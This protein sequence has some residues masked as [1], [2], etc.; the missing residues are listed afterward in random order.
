MTF[1][2]IIARKI[3]PLSLGLVVSFSITMKAQNCW[4]DAPSNIVYR[5]AAGNA[6]SSTLTCTDYKFIKINIHFM[7]KSNGSGN[8]R[9]YDD[10][11]TP[12]NPSANGYWYAQSLVDEANLKLANNPQMRLPLG[13]TTPNPTISIRLVLSGVYFHRDDNFYN[14]TPNEFT[15]TLNNTYGININ[16]EMNVYAQYHS[17]YA[18]SGAFGGIASCIGPCAT[19][20]V[21][22]AGIWN[23]PSSG[24]PPPVMAPLMNHEF[25]HN[26]GLNHSWSGDACSDTP[27]NLNEWCNLTS[28]SNNMMD[29]NCTQDAITPC[30]LTIMHSVVDNSY[31]NYTVC[32]PSQPMTAPFSM[33]SQVCNNEKVYLDGS[34]RTTK[35]ESGY[36]IEINKTNAYGSQTNLGNSYSQSFSG[37]YGLIDLSQLYTFVPGNFYKVKLTVTGSACNSGDTEETWIKI[38]NST[39]FIQ[40]QTISTT[41]SLFNICDYAI[42]TN[43]DG[44]QTS[45]NVVVTNTANLKVLSGQSI[46]VKTTTHFQSGSTVQLKA[47]LNF[48]TGTSY[49][50]KSGAASNNSVTVQQADEQNEVFNI[51]PSPTAGIFE[52]AWLDKN[53]NPTSMVIFNPMGQ[54]IL[55]R[56]DFINVQNVSFDFSNY[57]NGVYF[58]RVFSN[59]EVFDKKMEILK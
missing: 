24:S 44:T 34:W 42:G 45:G 40:N 59:G 4:L 21:K 51:F 56:N 57:P 55:E 50:Y 37:Q 17:A 20:W 11:K 9:E 18:N 35:P 33:R 52:I 41:Q 3:L 31:A 2:N 7:L 58:V 54:K 6:T 53:I 8:Y 1:I 47:D 16:S 38:D 5:E 46:V 27:D 19:P 39:S 36:T 43:V 13:N 23:G 49:S 48:A 14:L 22:L 12:A 25:G 10:G 32:C 15:S 26:L 30:Q 29:Y 28:G